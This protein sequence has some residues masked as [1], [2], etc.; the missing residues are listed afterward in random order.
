MLHVQEVQN[1]K[2]FART[3]LLFINDKLACYQTPITQQLDWIPDL[4]RQISS[5]IFGMTEALQSLLTENIMM[6]HKSII[7]MFC[8]H[9]ACMALTHRL[10]YCRTKP[11]TFRIKYAH[12]FCYSE[13]TT[14]IVSLPLFL[15]MIFLFPVKFW[16]FTLTPAIAGRYQTKTQRILGTAKGGK[17]RHHGKRRIAPISPHIPG[18]LLQ[19]AGR[20]VAPVADNQVATRAIRE[21]NHRT[22]HTSF[23]M[24]RQGELSPSPGRPSTGLPRFQARWSESTVKS[25]Q[26]HKADYAG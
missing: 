6:P 11:I 15:S 26:S 25:G 3:F 2:A 1:N 19:H 24:F 4:Y 7:G 23:I 18:R 8:T 14:I 20:G 17:D 10:Q 21:V 16:T 5:F 13:N 12:H 22:N 9:Q